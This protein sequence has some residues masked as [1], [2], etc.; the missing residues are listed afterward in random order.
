[1]IVMMIAMT[2]SLKASSRPLLISVGPFEPKIYGRGRTTGGSITQ[3]V[4]FHF[5]PSRSNLKVEP[6]RNGCCRYV[7]SSTTVLTTRTTSPL[8]YVKRSKYS[9][10]DAFSLYGT[11]FLRR[12]PARKFVVTTFSA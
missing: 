3:G 2:P 12:W 4:G 10:I 6:T 1:M 8:G 11:P 9:L 7:G 5:D